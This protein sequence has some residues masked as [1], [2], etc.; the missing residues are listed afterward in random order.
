MNRIIMKVLLVLSIICSVTLLSCIGTHHGYP[1][2]W[3]KIRENHGGKCLDLSGN[4]E[5][6]GEVWKGP[7]LKN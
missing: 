4:Y 5:N 3:E 2:T 6:S 7:Y 1:P